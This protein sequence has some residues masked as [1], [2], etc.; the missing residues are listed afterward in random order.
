MKELKARERTLR[1]TDNDSKYCLAN[2]KQYPVHEW[3]YT[4][5]YKHMRR[6]EGMI[7]CTVDC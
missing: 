5:L 7:L 6:K 1:E 4:I 2:V 3:E